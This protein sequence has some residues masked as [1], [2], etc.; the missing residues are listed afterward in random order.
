MFRD[1]SNTGMFSLLSL[2]PLKD[3]TKKTTY[4]KNK[5]KCNTE[6]QF[7][8]AKHY[9]LLKYARQHNNNKNKNNSKL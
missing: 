4:K 7:Q 5:I 3:S 6:R 9:N 8:I 1:I 2:L